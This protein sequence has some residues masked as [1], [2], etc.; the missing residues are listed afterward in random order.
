MTG[1]DAKEEGAGAVRPAG[2]SYAQMQ[3]MS[4]LLTPSGNIGGNVT[5]LRHLHCS[6]N[7]FVRENLRNRLNISVRAKV[8]P[9]VRAPTT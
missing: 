8:S 1:I 9:L 4:P 6:Q 2:D 5:L 3:G 7:I